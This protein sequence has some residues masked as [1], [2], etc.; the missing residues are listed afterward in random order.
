M[1][2]TEYS[3]SKA[4][5]SDSTSDMISCLSISH[6]E[7]IKQ[8]H[9]HVDKHE[10]IVTNKQDM[11]HINLYDLRSNRIHVFVEFE[12]AYIAKCNAIY[13]AKVTFEGSCG[14]CASQYESN[15]TEEEYQQI[16]KGIDYFEYLDYLDDDERA[17]PVTCYLNY[18][19]SMDCVHCLLYY[20]EAKQKL[21]E[22][23]KDIERDYFDDKV[24]LP[25]EINDEETITDA[26][27]EYYTPIQQCDKVFIE[28]S[29][30]K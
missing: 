1:L 5:A 10:I 16:Q 6:P 24:L 8:L 20:D 23:Y 11:I 27:K 17:C 14:C 29:V 2:G 22:K 19:E 12:D 21:H 30:S 25:W 4:I 28:I 18:V 3:F 26:Y 9:L 13:K 7:D 15:I